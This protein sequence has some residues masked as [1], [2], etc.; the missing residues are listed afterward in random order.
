VVETGRR[1]ENPVADPDALP[2]GTRTLIAAFAVS[3]VLHLLRPGVFEPIVPD[4]LPAHRA[5]VYV[6]GV[7]ELVCAV[8]LLRRDPWAPK[9]SALLL[10]AVWPAN[11][12]H[13]IDV[14][15]SGRSSATLKRLVWARLPLQLPM[16]R[17][18]L[19]SPTA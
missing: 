16:I 13:A 8:G 17:T 9:A 1:T 4:P 18:A 6:S 14:Q 12:Q 7:A 11:G 3:G 2:P 10:L 15:R 19:R 5:L